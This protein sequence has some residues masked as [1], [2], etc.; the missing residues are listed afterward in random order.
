M[1]PVVPSSSPSPSRLRR[2]VAAG[3]GGAALLLSL[4]APL[5][6]ATAAERRRVDPRTGSLEVPLDELTAAVRRKD[7]AEIGR[8]A[9]RIGP[10]RLGE[11]L[12]KQAPDAHVTAVLSAL[13]VLPG[14]IRLVGEVTD[15][16]AGNGGNDAVAP[17]AARTLGELLAGVSP[18]ELEDWDI[19][20][21]AVATACA[22]LRGVA[23]DAA[24][25]T[26]LRL[27]S[28]EALADA[29]AI[30]TTGGELVPL[31]RDP[32]PA[33]RRAAALMLRPQERLATGGFPAGTR[34]I[35]KGVAA[36]SVAAL[37]QLQA[38]PGAGV[39][40]GSREP[41]WAEVREAARRMVVASDTAP[42]DAVEMLDCLDPTATADRQLLETLRARPRSAPGERA[43]KILDAAK[44]RARP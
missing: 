6:S 23:V 17:L 38:Q 22:A 12:R 28:L 24:A 9:E 5:A 14:G 36:A 8:I 4:Q 41:I 35:D 30:C 16:L 15:L 25:A 10:A 18:G 44:G 2:A 34:D 26:P 39:R 29:A 7:R 3:V 31:L 1:R 13:P 21:D 40:G 32:S 33:V 43:G 27:A 37:C 42:E 20:P 11:A 19:A